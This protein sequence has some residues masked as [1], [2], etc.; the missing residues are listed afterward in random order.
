MAFLK[1]SQQELCP[2]NSEVL[3]DGRH[4]ITRYVGVPT[5]DAIPAELDVAYG[6][7]DEGD[8]Q[9]EVDWQGCRLIGKKLTAD[10]PL[11]GKD[12]RPMMTLVYEQIDD[13]AETPVGGTTERVLE[14][15]RKAYELDW[16]QFS[17]NA[18]VPGTVG[19][20]S[21]PN[22]A[23]A[24]LLKVEGPDDGTLRRIT[25]TYVYAGTL[26]TD[27]QTKEG[28]ALLIQTI[29]SAKTV[30]ATPSGYTLVGQPVQNP[31]GL[32]IYSYTFAKG[33]GEVSRETEY[34]L[35]E[36]SGTVGMTVTTVRYLTATSVG[37]NPIT[38]P[39]GAAT[40]TSSRVDQ[41]GYRVWTGIYASGTGTVVSGS[42]TRNNGKL[43]IYTATA[44]NAAPSTPSATIGGTVV[45]LD[46]EQRRDRFHEGQVIYDYRW[47][48]GLGVIDKRVQHRDGGLRLETWVSLGTSYNSGTMQ[49]AGILMLKD[50][51]EIDGMERYTVTCM[52]NSAGGD[53]TS[54]TAL[55]YGIKH[56]F[57]YPGRAKAYKT[58][59]TAIDPSG[60]TFTAHAYDVF[61]A[62]PQT[63]K[64]D[65]TVKVTYQNTNTIGS[66]TNTLWN[67]DCWATVQ[68]VWESWDVRPISIVRSHY[69]YRTISAT[70]LTFTAG[71]T[72][73]GGGT[74]NLSGVNT[75]C[76]GQRVYGLSSGSITV[77]GGPAAPDG[78][79]Y[80]LDVQLEPAFIDSSG[81]QYY[82]KT[83]IYA[84]IPTQTALPV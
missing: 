2:A 71:A 8:G 26:A 76:M 6:T 15:G 13:T 36:N 39:G 3:P 49:P 79:T 47:A 75:S 51:E 33:N 84:T 62:P 28:G 16:V 9:A 45:L 19:S 29:T 68:A 59:F 34:R 18:F 5:I 77:T 61:L 38:P 32:P 60:G 82:R 31:N 56:P 78:N 12:P 42:Q 55:T 43:V 11:P 10:V 40:I 65:A 72:I 41:D 50:I 52:Q 7:L 1:L 63:I 81:T 21:A 58:D 46:S 69:G 25:R 57:T 22:D 4:R 17:T 70:P 67:P 83:E 20:D 30:P 24:F 23:S 27:L 64:V 44:L 37:S 35:S 53:P 54:G 14:D 74:V 73:S 66:L 80:D 48:E